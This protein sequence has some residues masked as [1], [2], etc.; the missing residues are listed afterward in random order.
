M[1]LSA[2]WQKGRERR[3]SPAYPAQCCLSLVA[4]VGKPTV[5]V[6]PFRAVV[7]FIDDFV[8]VLLLAE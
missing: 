7:A 2:I 3:R 1:R 4:S 8:L 5:S 6:I